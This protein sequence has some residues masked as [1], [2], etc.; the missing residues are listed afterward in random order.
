MHVREHSLGLRERVADDGAE[1]GATVEA[2][3][4]DEASRGPDELEVPGREEA[5][6]E[7]VA[8]VQGSRGM[9]ST[10]QCVDGG[11]WAPRCARRG[12]PGHGGWPP[13]DGRG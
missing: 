5:E 1:R 4:A 3:E 6:G 8:S 7:L 2:G 10:M 9:Q 13:R 11:E 12:R